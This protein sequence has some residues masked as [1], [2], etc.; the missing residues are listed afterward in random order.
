MSRR[1]DG[2]MDPLRHFVAD[3]AISSSLMVDCGKRRG[4]RLVEEGVQMRGAG[5]REDA[6]VTPKALKREDREIETRGGHVCFSRPVSVSGWCG[7]DMWLPALG[8]DRWTLLG[9]A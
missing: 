3:G 5:G 6:V 9:V 2:A 7:V 8:C 1:V 4:G